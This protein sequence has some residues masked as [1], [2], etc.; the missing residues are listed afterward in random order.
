M[1]QEPLCLKEIAPATAHPSG[2][3]LPQTQ[4]QGAH[5]IILR[6]RASQR[7]VKMNELEQVLAR[8]ALTRRREFFL[9]V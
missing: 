8:T 2:P 1:R 9:K 5:G 4:Q 7:G 6:D 3:I